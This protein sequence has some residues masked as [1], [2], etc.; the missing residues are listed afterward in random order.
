M[1][2]LN[3]CE[4]NGSFHEKPNVLKIIYI[5]MASVKRQHTEHEE[6]SIDTKKLPQYNSVLFKRDLLDVVNPYDG[7]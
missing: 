7:K 2:N 1:N 5:K 4:E 3:S 6:L